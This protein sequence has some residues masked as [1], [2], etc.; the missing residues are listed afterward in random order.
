MNK[1]LQHDIFG[2]PV[3]AS[4]CDEPGPYWVNK[5]ILHKTLGRFFTHYILCYLQLSPSALERAKTIV[6]STCINFDD[7]VTHAQTGDYPFFA[8]AILDQH[9]TK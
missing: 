2:L 5:N 9:D 1:Q 4:R 6:D 7:L 8:P 3:D